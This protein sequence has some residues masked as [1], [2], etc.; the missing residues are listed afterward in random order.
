MVTLK[1]EKESAGGGNRTPT[2]LREPDF[3]SD[4]ERGDTWRERRYGA[5]TPSVDAP[6]GGV[7]DSEI[8]EAAQNGHTAG[9]AVS[10]RNGGPYGPGR[11]TDSQAVHAAVMAIRAARACAPRVPQ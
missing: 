9:A 1:A 7:G 4:S 11:C 3:E 2:P 6:C 8:G 10:L 5:R